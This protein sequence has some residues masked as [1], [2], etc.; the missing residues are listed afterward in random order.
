MDRPIGHNPTCSLIPGQSHLGLRALLS[1][2]L[3]LL[4]GTVFSQAQMIRMKSGEFDPLQALRTKAALPG[5][6]SIPQQ[7][8]AVLQPKERSLVI[9]Q[10]D[11]ALDEEKL[12]TVKDLGGK[13]IMPIPDQAYLVSMPTSIDL[14]A[15]TQTSRKS[16]ANKIKPRWVGG[17]EAGWKL[18]PA[19]T[20]RL[21]G[22]ALASA[23]ASLA[24]RD[25][26]TLMRYNVQL[27]FTG[28]EKAA[29]K[30]LK[31]LCPTAKLHSSGDA[32][33]TW[34]V[35]A[36]PAGIQTLAGLNCVFWIEPDY[37]RV[38]LGERNALTLAG[39]LNGEG[40]AVVNPGSYA[41]WLNKVGL[42][43]DGV[44]VQLIDDGL[45]QGNPSNTPGTTHP[46]FLGRIAG[47]DNATNDLLGNSV[48]GHGNIDASI[49]L[50]D[51]L[52]GMGRMTDSDGYVLGQGVAPKARVFATKVTRNNS[53]YVTPT[54]TFDS[55]VRTANQAGAQISSNSWGAGVSGEY[56]VDC[57][58]F[59][60]LTRDANSMQSGLQPMIFCFSAGNSGYSG[61][62]SV[63]APASAKNVISVGAT[64][65]CDKGEL[66]GAGVGADGSDDLRDMAY[67]SSRGPTADGRMAPTLVAPGTHITGAA[68]D[69]K[70]FNGCGVSGRFN[71][72]AGEDWSQTKYYP[73]RQNFY[74]W[75][76]GTSQACPT[77]AG[78]AAL[79]Y[80]F[81]K[82][83]YGQAPSPA[84]VKAALVAGAIDPAG[85]KVHSAGLPE[86]RKL[87]PVPNFNSGWGRVNLASLV[88]APTTQFFIDQSVVFSYN[89]QSYTESLQITD[90]TQPLR[91]VLAWTDPPAALAA[92]KTL[93][94]DLDLTMS[95]SSGNTWYGNVFANGQSVTG[96]TNDTL[97]NMECVFI[98]HP[99]PSIYTIT[100]KAHSLTGDA[101][102]GQGGSLQQDFALFVTNGA[103][104]SALGQL[105]MDK[106]Y[107]NLGTPVQISLSDADL[108]GKG[109]AQVSVTS[110]VSGDTEMLMLREI[111]NGSGILTGQINLTAT[112]QK[113]NNNGVLTVRN[114][115]TIL[116]SY[117]DVDT[118]D[119]NG[120]PQ[121]V[122]GQAVVDAQSPSAISQTLSGVDDQSALLTIVASEPTLVQLNVD[123]REANG[124]QTINVTN[125]ATVHE[126]QIKGLNFS[127][128]YFY[129]FTLTDRAGNTKIYDNSGLWY[130]FQTKQIQP[131]FMDTLEP[132]PISGWAHFASQ[133]LDDWAVIAPRVNVHSSSHAWF[134]AD[135]DYVK[136]ASLVTP[137]IYI[138]PNSKMKFWHTYQFESPGFVRAYD[139]GVIEI[140]LDQGLSWQDLGPYI[141]QGFYN[142]TLDINSG[143]PL[144]GHRAWSGGSLGTMREVIVD[145]S[146]FAGQAVNVRFRIGCNNAIGSSGWYI[147]DI[148]IFCALDGI[149]N[150][151]QVAFDSE[152]FNCSNST[153][154][155]T[156]RDLGLSQASGGDP[157]LNFRLAASSGY[158][159]GV[160]IFPDKLKRIDSRGI[161]EGYIPVAA[162]ST[163]GTVK[164]AGMIDNV[165]EGDSIR[166]IYNDPDVA[167]SSRIV[168]ATTVLDC[169][170][171]NLQGIQNTYIGANKANFIFSADEPV[172]ARIQYG[173][174]PYSLNLS[175][176]TGALST[177]GTLQLNNLLPDTPYFYQIDVIDSA[178]NVSSY[179]ND[180]FYY[181][182]KTGGM[183]LD[184]DD[185]E[186]SPH[187][188]WSHYAKQGTDTWQLMLMP[189]AHSPTHAWFAPSE[190]ILKDTSL[191]M[192][193]FDV[194]VGM[195][196]HFWHTYELERGNDGA[197][198][199]ISADG[200]S[201]WNDLGTHIVRGGYNQVIG[202]THGSP[203]AGRQAWSGGKIG[204][205]TEVIADL[206][207]YAGSNRLIRFRL[208]CDTNNTLRG[209]VID[210]IG[211][212]RITF[213][214]QDFPNYATLIGP[215][216]NAT[217]ISISQ[218]LTLSWQADANSN[219]YQ[220]Y[221]GTD[222]KA[223]TP[224]A[225]TSDTS[226]TIPQGWLT[227]ATRYY[228]QVYSMNDFAV[229]PGAVWTFTTN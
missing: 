62:S 52:A 73:A 104:Q 139:G 128:P 4:M 192:P 111:A 50:G 3:L 179:N 43:G 30:T 7:A 210:D 202:A 213:T 95:D 146:S 228:W 87:S 168:T 172:F 135:E 177:T 229:T 169:T 217:G 150:L 98:P 38:L 114:S 36:D 29:R 16:A 68:S 221:W 203:I 34:T 94:N 209:W 112:G 28:G 64:E 18:H 201:T 110:T 130:I 145:L 92:V 120:I 165:K 78:A 214:G 67:F 140:S 226:A 225:D 116:V 39:S 69:D 208:G 44:T 1:I 23:K 155:F 71:V 49:I 193:A 157:L 223:M 176:I 65:N 88:D 37:D 134:S 147:D 215:A 204:Q 143:N 85:G 10:W 227:A 63:A 47:I 48:N 113:V 41:A 129:M 142:S 166:L 218:P 14:R 42:S 122:T 187:W 158:E 171:P 11:G 186:P 56:T 138:R 58:T 90:P 54:R 35:E 118:P 117:L 21:N 137:S 148:G 15:L 178:R 31:Q 195:R 190:A 77:V 160:P 12:N 91:V 55:L 61:E 197:V 224:L 212:E 133:G 136:D 70:N 2:A 26:Q 97:N 127:K 25:T 191:Q 84:M 200:G 123:T 9:V 149:G 5:Q 173:T 72:L 220:V 144:G 22:Q 96:G 188:D 161:W 53:I 86:D 6:K 170:A 205:M 211:L 219:S 59:D 152:G 106:E 102:P 154:R 101:L 32:F 156:V 89:S 82:K 132:G 115:E 76:S 109:K 108:K 189:E 60:R 13:L 57:Q 125:F 79:Y 206:T 162:G 181:G 45:S 80:E 66:D 184:T 159:A 131:L 75:S 207:A 163:P 107:Y 20:K 93:V 164:V 83:K 180:G 222:P 19:V 167:G 183:T 40:S 121:V 105:T 17:M 151:A 51:P 182:V 174:S 24:S 74:T 27:A 103:E 199:E 126:L 198:I 33:E 185:L 124:S 99:L 153:L 119:A 8:T 46:D 175:T 100:V 216:N 194:T 81:H 196:L 141:L